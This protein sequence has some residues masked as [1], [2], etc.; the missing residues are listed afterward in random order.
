MLRLP[1]GPALCQD[2]WVVF[3][4]SSREKTCSSELNRFDSQARV[5]HL[6]EPSCTSCGVGIRDHLFWIFQGS[7]G[8]RETE[9]THQHRPSQIQSWGPYVIKAKW[10]VGRVSYSFPI[11]LH[12]HF[13]F[14]PRVFYLPHYFVLCVGCEPKA[15]TSGIVYSAI[16]ESRSLSC[17]DHLGIL[18]RGKIKNSHGF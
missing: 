7:R 1:A 10:C 3:F 14:L 4:S 13:P 6:Y 11:N 15:P 2:A 9:P 16:Q 17:R 5:T 8:S 18:I 12:S